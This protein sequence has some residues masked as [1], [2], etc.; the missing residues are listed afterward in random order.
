M[1]FEGIKRCGATQASMIT[2]AGP[3]LTVIAAWLILD[4]TL[5][6]VQTLGAS[7]TIMGV[8]SL[9][10]RWVIDFFAKAIKKRRLAI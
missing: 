6:S 5:S 10:S 2:L 9:K 7:I 3:V 1:L 8:A 4:E